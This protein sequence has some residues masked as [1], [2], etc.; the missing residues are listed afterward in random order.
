MA[1]YD[2]TAFFHVLPEHREAVFEWARA[3]AVL[4]VV[5]EEHLDHENQ[6]DYHVQAFLRMNEPWDRKHSNTW[7]SGKMSKYLVDAK[8]PN[9]GEKNAK[10]WSKMLS[11]WRYR[12][13][14]AYTLKDQ[15]LHRGWYRSH[16]YDVAEDDFEYYRVWMDLPT[17]DPLGGD[18]VA[19]P[20]KT[21]ADTLL[22]LWEDNGQPTEIFAIY[23]MLWTCPDTSP[24]SF[25]PT[26][27]LRKAMWLHQRVNPGSSATLAETTFAHAFERLTGG[28]YD[29]TALSDNDL[30][31]VFR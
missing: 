13:A 26:L 6:T 7:T 21:L 14:I 3:N 2:Y 18:A 31:P 28:V 20:K 29:F 10:R 9:E 15:E 16:G 25:G 19:K 23:K 17:P 27:L 11:H 5:S 30:Y 8:T 24:G 1:C 4:C 22:R 12:K